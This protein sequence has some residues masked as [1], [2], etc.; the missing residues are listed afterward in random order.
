LYTTALRMSG[1]GAGISKDR[2]VPLLGGTSNVFFFCEQEGAN[3]AKRIM[4]KW[5]IHAHPFHPAIATEIEEEGRNKIFSIVPKGQMR[6]VI[7]IAELKEAFSTQPG[8]A[9]TGRLFAIFFRM[10]FKAKVCTFQM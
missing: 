8:T 9:K 6:Q 10:G 4:K 5:L 1:R 2:K 7:L 3:D